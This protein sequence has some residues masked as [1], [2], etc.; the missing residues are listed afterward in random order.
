MVASLPPRQ[1]ALESRADGS[2]AGIIHVHT[3]RSDG[4]SS[5]EEIAA[6]AARAGLKFIIFTDHGDATRPPDP[7]A[8]R[9]GVLCIDGVEISTSGGHYIAVG[10]PEA[11]YPLGGDPYGVAEDVARLGG[12]G[13]AAHPDSPKPDLQWSDWTAPL[14][15][16]EIVNPDTS[17]RARAYQPAWRPRLRLIQGL[18]TYP[19]RPAETI[20]SLLTD[21][22]DNLARWNELTR[23]R[24][25]VGLAGA[26]AHAKL[27][28]MNVDPGDNRY[29]LP[30]PGYEASLRT[31]SVH[32]RP[33]A[34]LSGDAASD[35]AAVLDG[36][37]RG[38]VYVAVDGFASPPSFEFTAE[39]TGGRVVPVVEEGDDV[40][41]G[42]PL[43]LR[44]RSNAPAT[45]TTTVWQGST[46]LK[47]AN[48]AELVVAAAN[49]PA[50]YR[51]EI[52][53]A[54]GQTWL[55]SNPIY[56]RGG[57]SRESVAVRSAGQDALTFFD[58]RTS[59]AGWR[60]ESDPASSAEFK[61]VPLAPGS[62]DVELQFSY[63]LAAADASP[64]HAALL[65]ETVEA[66]QGTDRLAFTAHAD[67]P[68]RV[69]VQ[70][71]TGQSAG[72]EERWQRSVYLDAT[73][74][75]LVVYFD[76]M[77]PVGPTRTVEPALA[78]IRDVMFAVDRT[79]TRA[80]GS[81]R[82]SIRRVSLQR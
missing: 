20:A 28:L 75:D 76:E 30:L 60:T 13:I 45:F 40:P 9:N 64:P 23:G 35:M 21:S 10:L 37:R 16:M 32:V 33:K 65:M 80:G 74:R 72:P 69:S 36:M 7:P 12:F 57:V 1:L 56:V 53:T 63:Q 46:V 79:N 61:V 6:V 58:G 78:E 73:D 52:R 54:Q 51:V 44:V 39:R 5:P 11:P 68:M 18:L 62:P 25:V 2:V 31:L 14:G 22:P 42:E 34:P 41:A 8:Y 82:L 55:F 15:G 24:K 71:R 47:S 67:R 19:F 17:W 66:I 43:T 81:G 50:V 70:L 3:N 4:R 26:D 77:T 48:Q 27:A 29:S 38:H 49:V 59:A